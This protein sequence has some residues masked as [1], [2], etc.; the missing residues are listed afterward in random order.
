MENKIFVE[1]TIDELNAFK[2]FKE[3][4]IST[5]EIIKLLKYRCVTVKKEI[6]E[7]PITMEKIITDFGTI[8][9]DDDSKLYFSYTRKA[10]KNEH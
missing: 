8:Y 9:L 3:N 7:N 5:E 4:D 1:M 2:E 6:S 10:D